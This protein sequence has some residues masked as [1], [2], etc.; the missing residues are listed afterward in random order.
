METFKYFEQQDNI[1]HLK[2]QKGFF[3]TMAIIAF[4]AVIAALIYGTTKGSYFGVAI[5]VFIGVMGVLRSTA[6]MEFN[7][8]EREIQQKSFFFSSPVTYSF[9]D[10]DHFLVSKLKSTFIT[11][12]VSGVLVMER[13][14]K[15]KNILLRQC[16]FTSKPL[17][18]LSDELYV[19]LGL[20]E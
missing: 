5:L 13:N 12:G 14:G 1:Y 2:V 7:T 20:P 11:V 10:F 15:T 4:V 9:D 19:I 8:T 3:Y 18:R 16:F 6:S 17:Q